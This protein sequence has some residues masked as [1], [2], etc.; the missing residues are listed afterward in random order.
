MSTNPYGTM[1]D[2]LKANLNILKTI[3][4]AMGLHHQE[5]RP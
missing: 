2:D 1:A 5:H 3:C 4:E